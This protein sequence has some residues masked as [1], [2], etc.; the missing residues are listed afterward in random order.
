MTIK[1]IGPDKS[2]FEF[3]DGTPEATI[4]SAMAEHYGAAAAPPA[5]PAMPAA[6]AAPAKYDRADPRFADQSVKAAVRGVP[7]LGAFEPQASAALSAVAQPLTG[8]GSDKT[9]IA[10]RY[11]ANLEQEEAAKLDYETENPIKSAV[12]GAVGGTLALGGLG[13]AVPAAAKAMGMTGKLVPAATR[14][15]ASGAAIGA[16][17][18]AARGHD[19]ATGA[20][21]GAIT[22]AGGVMAG[23][24]IGKVWDA[25]R[26]MMVDAPPVPTRTIPVAGVDVPVP[27]SVATGNAAASELEQSAIHGGQGVRAQEVARG[28]R[29]LTEQAMGRAHADFEAGLD[30]TGARPAASPMAAGEAIGAEVS[31]QEAAR[32]AAEAARLQSLTGAGQALRADLNTSPTP[33]VLA[34]TPVTAAQ[35]IR[36]ALVGA[37]DRLAGRR[38]AAYDDLRATPGEFNPAVFSNTGARIRQDLNRGTD[39]VRIDDVR[40]PQAAAAL[41]DIEINVGQRR[42]ENQAQTELQRGPDGRPVE[43]P[44]TAETIDSARKRLISMQRTASRAA[45]AT[46]DDSDVRAMRRIVGAFDDHVAR[47]AQTPGGFTGNPEEL[48][49][50]LTRARGLHAELKRTFGPQN[51]QDDVGKAIEKIVGKRDVAPAELETIAPLLFGSTQAGGQVQGRVAQRVID[52]FGA[53][54]PQVAQL[55]QGLISHILDTPA[56]MEPLSHAKAADKIHQFFSGTKGVGLAQT[57]FSPSERARFLAHANRMR[58]AHD[59]VPA[60]QVEKMVAKW[61]GRDGGL[62]ASPK[63]IVDDLMGS[64]GAK[65]T[66][67]ALVNHLKRRLSPDAITTL[68]QGVWSRITEGADGTIPWKDQKVGQRLMN[69]INGDGKGL[70]QALYTPAE[71]KAMREIGEAHI[72]LLPVEGTTN[73]SKSGHV[74]ERMMRTMAHGILPFLGFSAGGLP[75][76]AAAFGAKAA[77]GRAVD[78]RAAKKTVERFYGPQ[79]RR[80]SAPSTLPQTFGALGGSSIATGE[81]RSR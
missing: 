72:K 9:S 58:S 69:F 64:T 70:A 48:L 26:G 6:P 7:I 29:E 55:K 28:H 34:D 40:T 60:D 59:P 22:G 30:P 79:P 16:G 20:Q 38:T 1:V 10:D 62:K 77:V 76:A 73:P 14:A 19:P 54:S 57:L 21:V 24:A 51:P 36:D 43:P 47:A 11:V 45:R 80:V 74:I 68:K 27:E 66:A 2:A 46:G 56:G 13:G 3:P 78:R 8:V 15:A 65:G 33:G 31:A 39:P 5:A 42:F 4:T 32:A 18:A 41:E 81:R 35:G 44:I 50:R 67:P 63:Q 37:R 12:E 25:A 75:G 17:D 71:L 49:N 61:A 52:I 53:D 23:K